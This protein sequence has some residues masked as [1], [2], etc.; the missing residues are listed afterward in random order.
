MTKKQLNSTS[1]IRFVLSFTTTNRK[2][3]TNYSK[4]LA[5]KYNI[6]NTREKI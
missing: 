6:F 5:M 1:H 2:D 3:L 4:N